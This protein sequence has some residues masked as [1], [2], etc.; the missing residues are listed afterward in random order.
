M[1]LPKPS[2]EQI[3]KAK[4]LI[5]AA[6]YIASLQDEIR[7]LKADNAA[8]AAQIIC[9]YEKQGFDEQTIIDLTAQLKARE[10]TGEL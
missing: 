3:I 6:T 8:K 7:A 2:R 1:T 10:A 4:E 5:E 9:L